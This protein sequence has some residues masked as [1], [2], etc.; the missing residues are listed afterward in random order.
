MKT[1]IN[2]AAF[3]DR[4]GVINYDRNYVHKW[5]DFELITGCE[6]ALKQLQ[7]AGYLLLVITNQSGIARGY[8]TLDDYQVLTEQMIN[9]F[10]IKGIVINKVYY[11]P[12]LKEANVKE[13]NIDCNCRKPK[14]GMIIKAVNEFNINLEESLLIGDKK[15]DIQAGKS[16]GVG[17]L[18]LLGENHS[19]NAGKDA[20]GYFSGIKECVDYHLSDRM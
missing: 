3:L 7:E 11:C 13:Y 5:D 17:S 6:E 12:H 2:K 1:L 15:I 4:D 14:D 9:Y 10:K 20:D 19:S 8:Y 18:Y 16:A